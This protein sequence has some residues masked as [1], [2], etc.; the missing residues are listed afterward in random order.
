MKKLVEEHAGWY[1][2]RNEDGDNIFEMSDEE[3]REL[4]REFVTQGQENWDFVR[5]A[6]AEHGV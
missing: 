3:A 5:Q 1:V 6:L 2:I 4:I